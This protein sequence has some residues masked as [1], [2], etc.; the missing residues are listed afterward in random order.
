M[1]LARVGCVGETVPESDPPHHRRNRCG[2]QRRRDE[3]PDS[4]CERSAR[5]SQAELRRRQPLKGR[6]IRILGRPQG[7]IQ[8]CVV[9]S[10][11]RWF[12]SGGIERKTT[13]ETGNPLEASRLDGVIFGIEQAIGDHIGDLTERFRIEPSSGQRRRTET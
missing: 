9:Q 12:R 1:L 6:N 10:G 3:D 4:N 5:E 2:D 11:K 13:A 8:C 7:R